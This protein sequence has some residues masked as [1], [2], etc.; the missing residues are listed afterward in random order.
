MAAD[1][2]NDGACAGTQARPGDSQRMTL[3]SS[4]EAASYLRMSKRS[5]E[6]L[7]Y[8][9]GGPPFIRLGRGRRSPVVYDLVD[10]NAWLLARKKG[11]TAEE[12]QT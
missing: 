3:L 12:G 8:E 7:R 11:S 9:G 6:D 4:G 10:L 5:L 1:D 2:S